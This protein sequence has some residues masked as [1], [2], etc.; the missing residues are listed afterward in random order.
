MMNNFRSRAFALVVAAAA[1]S[2]CGS[3][4]G[5]GRRPPAGA[6]A[7]PPGEAIARVGDLVITVADVQNRINAQPPVVRSQYGSLD[8]KKQLVTDLVNFEMM[9]AEAV[10]RGYDRDPDVV[11]IMKQQMIGKLVQKDLEAKVKTDDVSAAD[12]ARYYDEHVRDFSRPE[13]VQ[14][15]QILIKDRARA[16]R[17]AAE[18]RALP[19]EDAKAFRELV[20]RYSEDQDSKIRGGDMVPFD[21]V[22]AVLPEAVVRAAF[23]LKTAGEMTEPIP[24]EEGFRLLRLVARVPGYS[25][26]LTDVT[27]QIRQQLIQAARAKAVTDFVAGLRTQHPVAIDERNLAKVTI[28]T[29]VSSNKPIEPRRRRGL[30]PGVPG[31]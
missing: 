9:A 7:R 19:R 3:G 26:P 10:R 18:A 20:S 8:K 2:A 4:C 28:D 21:R 29:T 5:N 30:T 13:Q 15:S 12:I 14:V 1:A 31:L 17:V 22:S 24:T 25:R 16:A 27:A 6:S 11:R 23:A